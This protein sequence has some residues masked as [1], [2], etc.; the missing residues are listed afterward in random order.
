MAKKTQQS[1][2]DKG[3]G[4]AKS[5]QAAKSAAS[6][7][8]A[9]AKKKS[10]TKVKVKDKLNN[11]VFLDQ[12]RYNKLVGEIPKILMITRSVLVE[13][14]KVNGSISRALIK[15]LSSKGMIKRV[16]DAHSSFDLFT[17]VNAKPAGEAE[18]VT[19]GKKQKWATSL[20]DD[21]REVTASPL[22]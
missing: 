3:K 1:Q 10:W 12:A 21:N 19:T 4:A 5:A 18:E 22:N 16:G 20:I 2:A 15:D 9:K 8:G 7:K 6:K 17:G 13:K 11:D 14:F